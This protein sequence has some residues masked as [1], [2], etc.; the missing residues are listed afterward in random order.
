MN[1]I[2]KIIAFDSHLKGSSVSL[3]FAA[4]KKCYEKIL[5]LEPSTWTG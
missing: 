4:V 1:Q 3:S 5:I 2:I